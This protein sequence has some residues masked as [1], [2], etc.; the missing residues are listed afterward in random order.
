[1]LIREIAELDAD[2]TALLAPFGGAFSPADDPPAACAVLID[3]LCMRRNKRCLLAYHHVRTD[4]LEAACWRGSDVLGDYARLAQE[5]QALFAERSA[6]I[7]EPGQDPSREHGASRM[8]QAGSGHTALSLREEDY[9]REYE[10]LLAAYKGH[11]TDIDLAGSLEPPT[12]LYVDVRVL[13]D[14]GD[15]QTEYGYV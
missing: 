8:L 1:M 9:V 5:E 6:A 15:I 4:K 7:S 2:K 10:S 11:W 12:A 13:K 3:M 14:A